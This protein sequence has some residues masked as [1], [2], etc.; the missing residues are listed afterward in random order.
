MTQSTR[1]LAATAEL[2]YHMHANPNAIASLH[3]REKS[4]K[5]L[6]CT[7]RGQTC[8]LSAVP[9]L[10]FAAPLTWM[11]TTEKWRGTSVHFR[12]LCPSTFKYFQAPLTMTIRLAVFIQY[13][14]VTDRRTD[15]LYQY[16]ASVCWRAIKIVSSDLMWHL[17][18]DVLGMSF[19]IWH[20][21]F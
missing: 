2:L 4:A 20:N 5:L 12:P 9:T 14:N 15:L 21:N 17:G 8:E 7:S 6:Y 19:E 3:C 10:F 1:G 16:R 18:W 11:G 13:R